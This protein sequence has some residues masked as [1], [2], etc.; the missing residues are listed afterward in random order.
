MGAHQRFGVWYESRHPTTPKE[1]LVL[2][3]E[4]CDMDLHKWLKGNPRVKERWG[5]LLQIARGLEFIH[6]KGMTHRDMKPGNVLIKVAN[7]R[8]YAKVGDFG[9]TKLGGEVS[10]LTG[11]SGTRDYMPPE[12]RRGD[13]HDNTVDMWAFGVIMEEALAGTADETVGKDIAK[14]VKQINPKRR[15][16]ATQMAQRL[17]DHIYGPG[18]RSHRQRLQGHRNH[19]P[20]KRKVG[21]QYNPVYPQL[22]RRDPVYHQQRRSA[23]R[24]QPPAPPA[25][26]RYYPHNNGHRCQAPKKNAKRGRQR[27]KKRGAFAEYGWNI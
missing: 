14:L 8:T 16:S 5:V 25:A 3:V 20:A 19:Q 18:Y 2:R 7:G 21:N 15:L 17:E 12:Q 9:L 22:P 1:L 10:D 26:A 27:Q 6:A 11:S 24:P 13:P 4:L 23:R